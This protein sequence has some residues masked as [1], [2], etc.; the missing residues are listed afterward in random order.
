M[1]K[2]KKKKPETCFPLL[3]KFGW[4]QRLLENDMQGL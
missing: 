2:E 3:L 1:L 4:E